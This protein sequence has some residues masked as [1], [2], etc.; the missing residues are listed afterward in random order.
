[1]RRGASSGQRNLLLNFI[2]APGAFNQLLGFFGHRGF[3]NFGAIR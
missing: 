2:G 3:I 1:M